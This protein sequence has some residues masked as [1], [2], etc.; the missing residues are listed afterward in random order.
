M[1]SGD[2]IM[3]VQELIDAVGGRPLAHDSR[4][5]K[6]GDVFIA[7]H[8]E[9]ADGHAFLK[10]A[11]EAGAVAVVTDHDV[12]VSVPSF[13]VDDT[14]FAFQQLAKSHRE[15]FDVKTIAVTG[16][17]GKTTTRALL[18]S[19]FQ[20]AG[21]TLAS[22]G[23]YNNHF[24]VPLTLF[25]LDHSY[26]YFVSE[27]GANHMGE[28]ANL[29]PLVQPDVA[30]I[31]N[32]GPA[33]L[34]GFGSLENTAKAK[35]EIYG[36]LNE[37]G[38]AVVNADD[39]FA[40]F[41]GSVNRQRRVVTFG[42]DHA[43]DVMAVQV[44]LDV[45][46]RPTFTLKLPSEHCEVTLQLLGL[47]N[48]YN[49]LAA[50]AAGFALGLSAGQIKKGLEQAQSEKKRLNEYQILKDIVLIDDSYNANPLST[51]AAIETLSHRA[52]KRI[53]V[54]G[55]MLELG[56][57][58]VKMHDDIGAQAKSQGIDALYCFGELSR[59]AVERFG[60][61]AFHFQSREALIKSL[62]SQLASGQIILVK[63]SNSMKMFEVVE[64]LKQIETIV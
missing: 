25:Q 13:V 50:A 28:I 8:G 54:L 3:S 34:E 43:A 12:D 29:V 14:L 4:A 40:E 59:H 1:K 11:I 20:Q 35:S 31:T 27:I 51:R 46:G 42:I 52:G 45:S 58:A 41:L 56:D 36:G 38:V 62:R 15:Q 44:S 6:A 5:V 55:D 19:V 32:I 49:A 30:I 60:A 47:H 7:L 21:P 23:S 64:A 18:Q 10:Q 26:A 22:V 53:L 61:D 2:E 33:H 16:S 57:E 17:C 37:G 63:G 24:G 9:L 39:R 48:V